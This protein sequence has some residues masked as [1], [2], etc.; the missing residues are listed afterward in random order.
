M[1]SKLAWGPVGGGVSH[2]FETDPR[3]V[4]SHSKLA[5]GRLVGVSD[6][7]RTP[8]LSGVIPDKPWGAISDLQP[9]WAV[10]WSRPLSQSPVTS[11]AV[12]LAVEPSMRPLTVNCS[13]A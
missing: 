12:P 10:Q 9:R 3:I 7:K 11:R 5:W 6:P 2:A 4:W 1:D 8:G 13:S